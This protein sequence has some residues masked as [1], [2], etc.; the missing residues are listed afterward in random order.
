MSDAPDAFRVYV[1]LGSN[2]GRREE[3]LRRALALIEEKHVGAVLAVSSFRETPPWGVSDQPAFIN[4]AALIETR[5]PP[6]E[7]LAALKTI[8]EETGR[9]PTRRWGERVVDLDILL[10][11]QG[12]AHVLVNEDDLVIP[13]PHLHERA[14]ALEPLAEIDPDLEH[15]GM[16]ATVSVLAARL[17]E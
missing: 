4:A 12:D 16:N 8:E 3:N 15:P 7:L 11:K 1:G 10:C 17:A 5:L 9:T 6:R 14:F 2:Q 13:H